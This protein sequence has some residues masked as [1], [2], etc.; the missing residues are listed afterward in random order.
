MG[1]TSE[2]I[3]KIKEEA[4]VQGTRNTLNI[5]LKNIIKELGYSEEVSKESLILERESAIKSLRFACENFGENEWDEQLN[6]SDIIEKHLVRYLF[7]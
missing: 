7:D 3:E 2:Q 6:L 5:Q 1:I 4:Y